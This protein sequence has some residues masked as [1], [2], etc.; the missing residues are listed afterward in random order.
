MNEAD[1]KNSTFKTMTIEE[2]E[3]TLPNVCL[4]FFLLTN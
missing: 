2:L 4:N 1:I 3:E